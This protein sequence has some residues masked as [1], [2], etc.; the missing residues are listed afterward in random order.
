M[1]GRE[2]SPL[3]EVFFRGAWHEHGVGIGVC[4]FEFH[5]TFEFHSRR[6]AW[7]DWLHFLAR[8]VAEQGRDAAQRAG[9]LL[10]LNKQYQRKVAAVARSAAASRLLDEL[11]ASP[12]ITVS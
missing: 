5:G 10:D 4:I 6:G 8:G 2:R 1:V 12:F 7:A 11:F 9:R 3:V